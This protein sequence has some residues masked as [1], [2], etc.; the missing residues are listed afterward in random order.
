M[1]MMEKVMDFFLSRSAELKDEALTS[2]TCIES[3][4]IED[5][6]QTNP[7]ASEFFPTIIRSPNEPEFP[8]S[9]RPAVVTQYGMDK[10]LEMGASRPE[11]GIQ[12][13]DFDNGFV[14]QIDTSPDVSNSDV[15]VSE[16]ADRYVGIRG[17]KLK[18]N[19][20]SA[21][22]VEVQSPADAGVSYTESWVERWSEARRYTP[23]TMCSSY[24]TWVE[25]LN[26][27]GCDWGTCVER[28]AG[29]M[30]TGVMYLA[31]E[32]MARSCVR[33]RSKRDKM[34]PMDIIRAWRNNDT[35]ARVPYWMAEWRKPMSYTYVTAKHVG[36][37]LPRDKGLA[38]W[39]RDTLSQSIGGVVVDET[40]MPF[41]EKSGSAFPLQ[42]AALTTVGPLRFYLCFSTALEVCGSCHLPEMRGYYS[43]V[44]RYLG[45]NPGR[46]GR[47]LGKV[48]VQ[49]ARL[50]ASDV[51]MDVPTTPI[52]K[53]V[54]TPFEG[55]TRA[56]RIDDPYAR[57]FLAD[58]HG[59]TTSKKDIADHIA[60]KIPDLTDALTAVFTE[61]SGNDERVRKYRVTSFS[62]R[63]LDVIT[64]M[65]SAGSVEGYV[66]SCQGSLPVTGY[67]SYAQRKHIEKIDSSA[68]NRDVD[69]FERDIWDKILT[70]MDTPTYAQLY[71]DMRE[72][73]NSKSSGADKVRIKNL[74]RGSILG[75]GHDGVREGFASNRKDMMH[76]DAA[77]KIQLWYMMIRSTANRP[78]P[79][80]QRSVPARK[81]RYIYNLPI[82]QQIAL[83]RLYK[84]MK[85]H[86][87]TDETYSLIGKIGVPI[88]DAIDELNMSR[89]L[90]FD[91]E[92][93][94]LAIDA[95][96]LD[97]H[98]GIAHRRVL[99]EA[100]RDYYGEEI[101]EDVL[102]KLGVDYKEVVVNTIDSWND[103][104][105]HI[106]VPGAPSQLLH[107]DTQPSGAL[108]TAVDN[109]LVTVAMLHMMREKTGL[110]FEI[111][112]VW[113]DDCYIVIKLTPDQDVVAVTK[114]L[115]ELGLAAG[116]V[117]GTAAD[118][119]SGRSVHYLQKMYLGGQIISR[120]MAYDHESEVGGDRMPGSV[121]E[122]IDKARDLSIRGGNKTL[123]NM[124]QL[125]TVVNG[126]RTTQ[127]GRQAS[128]TFETM[129]AP[130]GTL[131][132]V[133]VG[134]N[135][136]NSKLYLELNAPHIFPN[137]GVVPLQ[138][139][140]KIEQSHR[141]GSRVLADGNQDVEISV[142]GTTETR[143]LSEIQQE[144][145][146]V[147]LIAKRIK[148]RIT[149][150]LKEALGE[151]AS[152][153]S[154]RRSVR[155]TAE[156]A[157]GD[158][159]T[160]KHLRKKFREKALMEA[161]YIGRSLMEAP[162]PQ[163]MRP[164]STHVGLRVG[165]IK[166]VYGFSADVKMRLPTHPGDVF[167]VF[168]SG[169]PSRTFKQLWTPYM[170]MP[171][172]YRMLTSFLGIHGDAAQQLQ[173]KS[174]IQ[175]FS[176]GAFRKDITAEEVM[177]ALR[178]TPAEHHSELL[179]YIGFKDT[180]IAKAIGEVRRIPLYQDMA[181]A[182]EYASVPDVVKSCS[183][184]NMMAILSLTSPVSSAELAG[185]PDVSRVVLTH[186]VSLLADEMNV[187]CALSGLDGD[188]HNFIR[189]PT[190]TI[191]SIES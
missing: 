28:G 155:N 17:V 167:A 170:S 127:Y 93:V 139:I 89:R 160:Q 165:K 104:Y 47:K 120:R 183:S 22:S 109:S 180:E 123:L 106:P 79:S 84:A 147:L 102:E 116:Q 2:M 41:V 92:L 94:C 182:S 141:V 157:V 8:L 4:A 11:L 158:V 29:H 65:M 10:L 148:Q 117:L 129:A 83:V 30:L 114:M 14:T 62:H 80:G 13:D 19:P 168:E 131:N 187:V 88:F 96:S 166:I 74:D 73:S 177:Q 185:M 31:C 90:A 156:N 176:P 33:V 154:Y 27:M 61:Y 51:E 111:M 49:M 95:S 137:G 112:R 138:P 145:D 97:Q 63:L 3:W 136:P 153:L 34:D 77:L 12:P 54:S 140:A 78:N 161:N 56:T 50:L 42:N 171:P 58:I 6:E 38:E 37:D 190:V 52:R 46:V 57:A 126:C 121:G 151:H 48:V 99:I 81:L 146:Q 71:H 5:R 163:T 135:S 178:R 173:I 91:S 85:K 128:A 59:C 174:Y 9:E 66:R 7:T 43:G 143:Q 24:L 35:G 23:F 115:D 152:R 103:S 39:S 53:D 76:I 67:K 184:V 186:L 105:Y 45:R 32:W 159:L 60:A 130:G 16:S 86:M 18:L 124:L 189:L 64:H 72:L 100:I 26:Q 175:K 25:L 68:E 1:E 188:K 40:R 125:M 101:A 164:S 191:S 119:T 82:P 55:E 133:L 179:A 144:T 110:K 149:P 181:D 15:N 107:V 87:A 118:S 172:N 113:G 142:G 69:R 44:L 134:F 98:I 150:G 122:F 75:T 36:Y 70:H 108:T 21:K 169:L 132:R 20:T 162:E